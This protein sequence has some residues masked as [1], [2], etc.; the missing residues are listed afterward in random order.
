V[1]VTG[2]VDDVRDYLATADVCVVP[3]HVARGIQNKLL[4]AM[5]MGKA[6]VTTPQALEGVDAAPGRDLLVGESEE[7]FA[8]A[9]IALLRDPARAS[10][11]GRN[12]RRCVE[13]HY[14]WDKNLRPLD[15]ILV[16]RGRQR[17]VG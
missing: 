2:F 10:A 16:S 4:E 13:Q 9:T 8:A 7:S 3:L 12:A 5:A 11:I 15:D 1:I 17:R 14:V 6:V